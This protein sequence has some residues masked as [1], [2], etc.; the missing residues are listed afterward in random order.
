MNFCIPYAYGRMGDKRWEGTKA[1]CDAL[2]AVSEQLGINRKKTKFVLTA[3]FTKKFPTSPSTEAGESIAVEMNC[4]IL[5]RI[6]ASTMV[7]G[8]TWGTYGETLTSI[9]LIKEVIQTEEHPT[10]YVSTNFGHMLRVRLCWL[11]L[12][13]KGW[14]VKFVTANHSSTLKEYLQEPVKFLGY[15]FLFVSKRW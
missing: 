7:A 13:P 11:F 10:V 3:G 15:F 9:N 5:G 6:K 2:I 8:V 1:R 12:K 4:Y 14:E